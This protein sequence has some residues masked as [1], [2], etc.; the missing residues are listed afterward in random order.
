MYPRTMFQENILSNT[1]ELARIMQK[2][3][4]LKNLNDNSVFKTQ[5]YNKYLKIYMKSGYNERVVAFIDRDNGN[6]YKPFPWFESTKDICGNILNDFGKD[7]LSK[8]GYN[9]WKLE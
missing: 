3:F 8:S 5:V 4:Y 2:S 9:I 1:K 7:S 6:I